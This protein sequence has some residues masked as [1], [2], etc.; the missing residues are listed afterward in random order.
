MVRFTSSS[1]RSREAYGN[2][3]VYFRNPKFVNFTVFLSVIVFIGIPVIYRKQNVLNHHRSSGDILVDVPL[4]R[5]L[6]SDDSPDMLIRSE[7]HCPDP[8]VPID[9]TSRGSS[10]MRHH[11]N[12]EKSLRESSALDTEGNDYDF[13][14]FGDSITERWMGVLNRGKMIKDDGSSKVFREY[15]ETQNLSGIAIGSSADVSSHL[16]YH[17][18]NGWLPKSF[19]PKLIMILIGTNDLGNF[20]CSKRTVLA[21]IL[22]VASY[23][24]KHKPKSKILIHGLLPR[25][26]KK[27]EYTL[28]SYWYSIMFINRELKKFASLNQWYYMDSGNTFLVKNDGVISIN[29]ELMTDGL[30][31]TVE[32]YRAWAPLIQKQIQSILSS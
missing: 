1:S 13:C 18:H 25:S 15:F 21:G 4:N 9:D 2:F 3:L 14:M 16:L 11:E 12:I 17:L 7:C 28:E 24:Q 6:D 32:G 8:T 23:I 31:P 30:H 26:E 20:H 5:C 10:F 27:G 29:P 19:N 22:N